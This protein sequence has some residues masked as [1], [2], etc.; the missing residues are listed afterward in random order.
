MKAEQ[1]RLADNRS[2]DAPWYRWGPYLSE[3][4]WGTVREDYSA[5]GNAWVYF[6]HD[7]ARS[8]AYRWGEDGLGGFCDRYAELCFALAF[9]NGHDPIL[10]ER[11]FGLTNPQGNHGEDVKEYY[12]YL[13]NTPTHSYMRWLYKYPQQ[14]FPYAQLVKENRDRSRLQPEFELL[15]TG[16]FD[17]S[18]YFDIIA[19]YA[20]ASPDDICIQIQVVNRS[21]ETAAIDVLP[22]LWFRNTW[23]WTGSQPRSQLHQ[24]DA[25][26]IQTETERYGKR[27]LFCH[28]APALLFTNNETNLK[29]LYGVDNS[30][31]Y[32]KDAFH[33]YLIHGNQTAINPA[34]VGTK[35][36]AHYHLEIK[37]GETK[38]IQL[39]FTD[40]DT[41]TPFDQTFTN[42]IHQ[43]QQE[44]DEFYQAL[45]PGLDSDRQ[46]I[47]RQALA[48]LLWSKQVYYY[49]V[50]TWLQGDPEPPPPP[51]QHQQGRNRDWWTLYAAEPIAMPDKW[52]YP[53][54][55][56]WDLA[57]HCVALAVV[58]A[59]FAKQQLMLLTRDR[60]LHPSGQIPAYEWQFSDVNP[61]VQAWATWRVY[62]IEQKRTG[63]GDRDFLERM[64]HR[65]MLNFTWWVNRKDPRGDNL[66]QGGFLGL[67]NIGVFDRSQALPTGGYLEQA[68]GTAW[69]GLFALNMLT[70]ALELARQDKT[71]GDIALKFFEHFLYIANAINHMGQSQIALW[72]EQD[73]FYYDV[74]R[75]PDGQNVPLKVRSMVG[76]TPLFAVETLEPDLFEIVPGFQD[77]MQWFLDN[78]PDLA[79][80]ITSVA[81]PGEGDRRLLSLT[82]PEALRRILQTLL[83]EA[84]FLS[85]YGI[86]SVSQYHRE[87]PFI[88]EWDGVQY[89]VD[90]E[91]AESITAQFGGNSNWRGPIWFPLNFLLIESLQK[92]HHYL[93]DDF[94]VACPTG[95]G[96]QLNLWDIATHLEDRLIRIFTRNSQGQRPLYG[97]T[98]LFQQDPYW[99]DLI[100][101]YEY[102]HG[103]NG[104]G[105]GASH[106]TGWT[107]LVAKLIQQVHTQSSSNFSD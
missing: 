4:Q 21:A 33:D 22:T 15:D 23:A 88:Y 35:A 36:A 9:W 5:D 63:T 39:R 62:K 40:R 55:A 93:G 11:L 84:E 74:L 80:N 51:P 70:M 18:R 29:R 57:F 56:A 8:R 47:Q 103:D 6:P 101:F 64:F 94:Q 104:A 90:Y 105:L 106:Q 78:R 41:D 75:L 72:D 28:H 3:R 67:D 91:P 61:P 81:I 10:K 32:V 76:L 73:G 17:S 26:I 27:W 30:S 45:N 77:Q 37:A 2:P 54:F 86:R 99:R 46:N 98:T 44:A 38:I 43:R 71:Y 87:H 65:L 59:A 13:D 31:A 16:I 89:K 34:Q 19:E 97:G 100:L 68:D 49:D 85:P 53:W 60:Y 82:S 102:F 83:D 66:F 25:G 20:K 50:R 69:M 7:H 52:E 14:A 96:F 92:F 24:I 79:T 12:F 107:A 58:D 42:T 48:G 95:S 1:Q